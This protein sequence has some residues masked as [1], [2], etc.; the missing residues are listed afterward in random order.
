MAK[1]IWSN[2][3]V[4]GNVLLHEGSPE[5]LCKISNLLDPDLKYLKTNIICYYTTT[6]F[7]IIHT[8]TYNYL[9]KALK[10]IQ[11]LLIVGGLF[12]ISNKKSAGC[13]WMKFIYSSIQWPEFVLAFSLC[14]NQCQ[15]SIH[16][17]FHPC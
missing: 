10:H 4:F 6:D 5:P 7:Q 3:G 15:L 13:L 1:Q 12:Q 16:E 11:Q 8:D 9:S 17:K 2:F 14:N